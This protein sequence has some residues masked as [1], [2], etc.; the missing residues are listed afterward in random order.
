MWT[1]FCSVRIFSRQVSL[2]RKTF[3]TTPLP[4]PRYKRG[5]K[6]L[7]QK[8]SDIKWRTCSSPAWKP[9]RTSYWMTRCPITPLGDISFWS[10]AWGLYMMRAE[11]GDRR[12]MKARPLAEARESTEH[13]LM[14]EYKDRETTRKKTDSQRVKAHNLTLYLMW[15]NPNV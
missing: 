4:D 14:R 1:M 7:R 11:L 8:S 12:S 6:W 2:T 3:F 10:C 5:R 13:A 15:D 9:L